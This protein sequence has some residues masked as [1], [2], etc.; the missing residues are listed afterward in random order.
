MIDNKLNNRRKQQVNNLMDTRFKYDNFKIT[1]EYH[2]VTPLRKNRERNVFDF[3]PTLSPGHGTMGLNHMSRY[4]E[5]DQK[6][7]STNLI[8]ESG[9]EGRNFFSTL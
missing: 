8:Q 5:S 6:L 4:H 2:I 1:P 7:I 3:N 9:A